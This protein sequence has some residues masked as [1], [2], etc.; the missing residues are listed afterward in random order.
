MAAAKKKKLPIAESKIAKS[1]KK[2]TKQVGTYRSFRLSRRIKNPTANPIPSSFSIIRSALKFFYANWRLFTMVLVVYGLM[3]I[4]FV[5]GAAGTLG[6]TELRD[7]LLQSFN[8]DGGKIATS[9]NLFGYLIGTGTAAPD[10]ISAMYQTIILIIFSM[11]LIWTIRKRMA[12]I[13]VTLR[14]CLYRS[15]TQLIPF[16]IVLTVIALQFVPL[17][18]GTFLFNTIRISQFELSA[19]EVF[20]AG[21]I[22]FGFSLISFYMLSSSVF[23]L[24]IVT[25]PG[26]LP[27]QALRTARKL[28]RH[29]RWIIARRVLMLPIILVTAA[30]VLFLP[31]LLWI[32]GIAEGVYFAAMVF[33]TYV[34]H[35]YFYN[36]Y[37]SLL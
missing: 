17:I 32:T 21:F 31:L 36:L 8:G 3:Q 19:F 12:N 28:V 29:R 34:T 25:L 30:A 4:I 14:D 7:T 18:I 35:Y 11:I 33:T 37:R 6:L 20:G 15:T 10:D 1:N 23:A 9:L 13:E 22:L 24:Y 2:R 27:M 26:T 5:Y 16:L